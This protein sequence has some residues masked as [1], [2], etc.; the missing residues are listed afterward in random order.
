[1]NYYATTSRGIQLSDGTTTGG[2]YTEV[3]TGGVQQMVCYTILGTSLSQLSTRTLFANW[4]TVLKSLDGL[5]WVSANTRQIVF[6][7][8]EG[9]GSNTGTSAECELIFKR[10]KNVEAEPKV[11][12]F[13]L[14]G[15]TIANFKT[16]VTTWF[17]TTF[18]DSTV[19]TDYVLT[20]ANIL[21]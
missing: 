14:T 13:K 8:S 18:N 7:E 2:V 6:S 15:A 20:C 3:Y 17:T 21:L 9:S 16:K 12:Q 4:D 1:M 5:H 11:V 10:W 19:I